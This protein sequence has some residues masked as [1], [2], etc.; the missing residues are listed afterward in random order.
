LELVSRLMERTDPRTIDGIPRPELI[1]TLIDAREAETTVLLAVLAEM[2]GDDQLLR[3]RIG[4]ELAQRPALPDWL[5]QL[6]RFQVYRAVEMTHIL[7]DGDNVILGVRLAGGQEFTCSIYIDHN[8]GTLVKDAMVIS[9]PIATV[10]AQYQQVADD[11][12]THW[13]DI[14]L[15][16]ARARI[17]A[18]I[19]LATA[20]VPPF[21]TESWPGCRAL[22]EWITRAMP[23]GGTGYQQHRWYETD[24]EYLA[25]SF[26]LSRYGAP[27]DDGE[28]RSLLDAMLWCSTEY[29]AGGPMKWSPVKVELLLVDGLPRKLLGSPQ[30]LTLVPNLLKAFIQFAH[31]DGGVRAD[32]T[33]EALRAVERWTPAYLRTVPAGHSERTDGAISVLDMDIPD[34]YGDSMFTDWDEDP[35]VADSLTTLS[36]V[37]LGGLAQEVG[38]N[39]A[40]DEM[41]DHPLPDEPFRWEQIP[42]DIVPRVAEILALLDDGCDNLFDVEIRTASR[43]VLARVAARDPDVFR[44]KG[45]TETAAAAILWVIAKNNKLIGAQAMKTGALTAHFGVKGSLSQRATTILRAGGFLHPSLEPPLSAPEYLTAARRREI[46]EQR[47]RYRNL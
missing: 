15:S 6:S 9:E 17:E 37:L 11:P 39:D 21:E 12:D 46:I 24:R 27:L 35:A 42:D 20:T 43:R 5:A 36:E 16:D 45:R 31:A 32:L 23:S 22:V 25:E 3:A 26:F 18:A 4:R 13:D 47:E 33:A 19:A 30:Q 38:G 29:G 44:R 28:H 8:V 2:N 14:K 7:G 10:I 34:L 1:R 40:L 41:H